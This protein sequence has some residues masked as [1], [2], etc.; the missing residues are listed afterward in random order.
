MFLRKC[1]LSTFMEIMAFD[2]SLQK[3]DGIRTISKFY[4]L[5]N[6]TFDSLVHKSWLKNWIAFR[7]YL[8]MDNQSI[9]CVICSKCLETHITGLVWSFRQNFYTNLHLFIAVMDSKILLSRVD[10]LIIQ[11]SYFPNHKS[12]L[13]YGNLP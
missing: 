4:K 3:P 6:R 8:K 12:K 11:P 13:Y 10:F 2:I 7:E 9:R 1:S 5:L